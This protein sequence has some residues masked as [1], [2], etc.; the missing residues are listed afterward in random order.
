MERLFFLQSEVSDP[1]A[2]YER[3]RNQGPVLFCEKDQAWAMH[4]WHACEAVLAC[5][6]ALI[7]VQ[8]E[9]SLAPLNDTARML[10]SHFAR[11]ANPPQHETLRRSAMW[12]H[13]Q[14]RPVDAGELTTRLLGDASVIDWVADIAKPLPI[15]L[16]LESFG[17]S[18]E[19]AAIILPR[20][21]TLTL[22]M[23]PRRPA[24]AIAAVNEAA[25]VVT[26]CVA[27]HLDRNPELHG[28]E[29]ARTACVANLV[30][31]LI[32]SVHAGRGLLS[33]ALL[34]VL[35]HVSDRRAHEGQLK[36]LVLE[37][38]RFDPPIQNTQRIAGCDLMVGGHAIR[39]GQTMLLVLAAANRDPARFLNPGC[40]DPDR[41]NNAQHL[42]HGAGMHACVASHF[43]LQMTV[44]ALSRLFRDH[45]DVHLE[46]EA[47][48]CEPLVNARLP[49][50]IK[51]ELH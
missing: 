44:Q 29:A 5:R 51:L 8:S 23:T 34:Q 41:E 40:F 17:F 42:T 27:R 33:N 26:D 18:A 49:V 35:H 38:L 46:E 36:K 47:L 28:R 16:L 48:S 50:R 37:T 21:D 32:Q 43:S 4:S 24:S 9:T 10:I 12:L 19:A 45:P 7:P 20:M 1:Y 15:L 25:T 22:L 30:G 2:V 11:L 3:R 14:R 13:E 39:A 6:D 31:L